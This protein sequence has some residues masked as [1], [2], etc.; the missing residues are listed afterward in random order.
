ME[1]RV[2][3]DGAVRLL[4]S[5]AN[6]ALGLILLVALV[7]AGLRISHVLLIFVLA[8]LL[9]YALHPLVT[10]LRALT[11]GR[12]S[13]GGGVFLVLIVFITLTALL[14]AAAAGPTTQQ[15]RQ[16]EA[17]GPALRARADALAAGV[18]Q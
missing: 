1:R 17:E 7:W 2:E 16:L 13:Q 18:D 14:V 8:A 3:R 5:L 9:A 11:R 12:L 6:I 15:I 10:R 4:V